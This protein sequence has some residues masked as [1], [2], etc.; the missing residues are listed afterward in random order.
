MLPLSIRTATLKDANPIASLLAQ[1]GYQTPADK[2]KRL[3]DP[4]HDSAIYVAVLDNKVVGVMS[5]IYFDYLPSAERYCRIVTLVVDQ[6]LR[7]WGIGKALMA[8]AQQS[9][10]AQQCQVLELT[11]GLQRTD[12][13]AF[14]EHLGFER[15]S[16]KY[17]QRLPKAT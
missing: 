16:Y 14:Y 7:G 5:L 8:Q 1:L 11:T 15:V 3:L 2:L 4:A 13:H 17:I 10:L 9:A 12:A 6:A